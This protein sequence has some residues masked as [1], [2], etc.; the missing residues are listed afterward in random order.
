MEGKCRTAD[1]T[2]VIHIPI[3]LMM[4]GAKAEVGTLAGL[5]PGLQGRKKY[6]KC[7]CPSSEEF[8]RNAHAN[9]RYHSNDSIAWTSGS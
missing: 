5:F 6:G 3:Q 9:P 4:E 8:T 1:S 7:T 2:G